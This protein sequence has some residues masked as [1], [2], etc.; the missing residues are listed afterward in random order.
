MKTKQNFKI[1]KEAVRE[2]WR[3][4]R[5]HVSKDMSLAYR[6]LKKYFTNIKIFGYKTGKKCGGW[7]IPPSWNVQKGIL[8]DPKGKIIADFHKNKLSLWTYS[9]SFKGKIEKKNLNS[10]ILSNPK[11]PNTTTFHFRNQYNFWKKEWGFSLPYKVHKKL[12]NGKY[13]VDIKTSFDKGKL[14]MA[15]DVHYGKLKD[16]FLFVGHFDHPQM[17]LDGLVGCLA[18]HELMNKIKK[19]KTKLTYRMLSTVEIIGSV[20]YTAYHAKKNNIKEA[21]FISA[22]GSPQNISYQ[23]TFSKNNQIDKIT[24]HVLK[25]LNMNFKT[26]DFR[27]GVIG[28]DEIA[29]DTGG[30]NIPC[31]SIAR[32]PFYSYH[33]DLDTPSGISWNNFEKTMVVLEEIIHIFENNSTLYRNFKTLP[34]LSSEKH[35]LYLSPDKASGIKGYSN[36]Y[37]DNLLNNIPEQTVK[38]IKKNTHKFNYLMNSLVNMCEGDKTILDVA[39]HAE[40][41]FRLVENYINLWI[42]KKLIKKTWKHPFK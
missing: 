20:F 8:K 22:P 6:I 36:S 3:L 18:G 15:E 31:G 30:V 42:K 23:K 29:Y 19:K 7:T 28:N 33:T 12:K 40:L 14:E 9:P 39:N 41:P 1:C 27:K 25:S 32:S 34:R 21:L 4:N 11:K 38:L 37:S 5:V 16:S 10:K 13:S 35:D 24:S 17:C 2:I 26:Y